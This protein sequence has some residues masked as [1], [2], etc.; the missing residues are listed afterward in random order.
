MKPF[1]KIVIAMDGH[2]VLFYKSAEN[3]VPILK[4]VTE[5][6][7]G[8]QV[9]FVTSYAQGGE[10]LLDKDFDSINVGKADEMRAIFYTNLRN[11]DI[12]HDSTT[13]II[14]DEAGEG[15]DRQVDS[16]RNEGPVFSS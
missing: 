10:A 12:F 5:S 8:N 11:K 13:A 14:Q 1:A 4:C 6:K 15:S 9:T 16:V 3:G 2:Q 7:A